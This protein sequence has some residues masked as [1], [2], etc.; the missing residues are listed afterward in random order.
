M[1]IAA[2]LARSGPW[3]PWRYEAGHYRAAVAAAAA[4][5]TDADAA[6]GLTGRPAATSWDPALAASLVE[7]G[8][9]GGEEAVLDDLL[10]DLG[11]RARCGAASGTG[12][13]RAG[14]TRRRPPLA[15]RFGWVGRSVEI[16]RNG[17]G[18]RG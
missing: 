17:G 2:A 11:P 1:R 10:A 12:P 15:G 8:V 5:A 4:T 3:R 9:R 7:P 18:G 16:R 6:P 14:S 13:C